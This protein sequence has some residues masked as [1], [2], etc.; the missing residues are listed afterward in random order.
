NHSPA[1]HPIQLPDSGWPSLFRL[2]HHLMEQDWSRR[3][4]GRPPRRPSLLVGLHL[5]DE[6][7]PRSAVGALAQPLE[8]LKSAGLAGEVRLRFCHAED[9]PEQADAS[10][11]RNSSTEAINLVD[12]GFG[13]WLTVALHRGGQ[14]TQ[15]AAEGARIDVAQ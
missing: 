1:Q 3:A 11:R 7:V 14:V 15:L 9:L 10:G 6:R 5:L 8:R 2:R 12:I 13:R 4:G